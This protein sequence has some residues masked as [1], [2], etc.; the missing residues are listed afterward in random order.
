MEKE[1][2]EYSIVIPAY[3][4]SDKITATLTQ[5]TVFMRNFSENFE[6]IVVDDGSTDETARTV[7]EYS[8]DRPEIILIKNPHKGK[9]VAL[10]TGVSRSRGKYVYLC[11]ADLS[12]PIS[13]IKKMAV[14]LREHDYDIAIGSREGLGAQ[15]INE[16]VYRHVMGRVFNLIVQ[17]LLLPGIS[18]T[19]CG[20]KLLKGDQAREIFSKLIVY[21]P[22]SR[23]LKDAYMG[24]FD[25]EVLHIARKKG[26]KIKAVPVVWNYVQTTRLNA[27]SDSLRMIQDVLRIK[28]NSVKGLY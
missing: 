21:N 5:V 26:Y 19:Q 23:V 9:G 11:D 2:V 1:K 27:I 3:N 22:Q 7:T 17:I 14:W 15:R 25:V 24:A 20:F 10:W 6:V 4:E 28:L 12:A 8:A 13:E 18:D 16:P